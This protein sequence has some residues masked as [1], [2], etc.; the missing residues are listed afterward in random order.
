MN[1]ANKTDRPEKLD[2]LDYDF[3]DKDVWYSDGNANY[4]DLP[5]DERF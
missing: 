3:F 4:D 5:D 2:C 1:E